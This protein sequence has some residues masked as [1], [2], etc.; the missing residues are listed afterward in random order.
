MKD[1]TMLKTGTAGSVVA[2][3]CC[4]TPALVLVFGAVGL[5]AW[6]GRIDYVLLPALAL[7]LA[8]TGYSLYL[9]RRNR[10]LACCAGEN[11]PTQVRGAFHERK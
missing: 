3:I 5:S 11:A 7:F 6:L 8:L 2:A 4:F 10:A 9:R 1:V